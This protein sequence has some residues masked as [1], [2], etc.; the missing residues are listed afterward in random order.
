MLYNAYQARQDF[1]AP[2]RIYADLTAAV[3]REPMAGPW[4]NL[5]ARTMGAAAELVARSGL[6][7]ERPSYDIPSIEVARQMADIS[8]VPVVETPFGTLLHF[9]KSISLKQKRVL[10]VAPLAGH[11]ATLLRDT[12][13]TLLPDHD[14]F[15]TD[16]NNARDIS[17]EHG[18]FGLDDYVEH[19]MRFIEY[20][21]SDTHVIG[22]C[23]PCN[24]LLATIAL[25][26]QNN[27]PAQPRS[28]TLMAG[29]VDTR[30]NP[31]VVNYLATDHP[32]E[33]FEKNLISPVPAR[34]KGA[35][36]RVYPGFLQ[37]T[38]FMSMNL[39]RHIR[40]HLDLFEHVVHARDD[41]AAATRNFYDEYFA[42][43]DMP[44]EFYLETVQR[45]FQDH[46][47]ARGKF[48]WRGQR[49]DLSAIRKTALLTVEGERDDICA[50]GQ[51]EAAHKLTP[52]IPVNRKQHHLQP[53]VGHYGVFAGH[54]W[55]D[56]IYPIVRDFIAR[57]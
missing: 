29:P 52:N 17:R 51:T 1:L 46:D 33:W 7:H 45:V 43:F 9:R 6:T 41:Q 54:R 16:W 15:I 39:P 32:I 5:F 49:A 26:A 13:R 55:Q 22:V 48:Q 44:A 28:L 42:V 57:A 4:G 37:V 31:T 11:F 27:S 12:I 21:G 36:R 23:Q 53:K 34:F 47:L 3:L 56:E 19:V 14:V 2:W 8:E 24:A 10:L 25:M 50:P 35:H 38:G 20:L 18:R 30:I 40:A